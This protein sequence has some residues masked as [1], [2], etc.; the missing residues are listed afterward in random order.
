VQACVGTAP[1]GWLGPLAY[2]EG[3]VGAADAP[4]GC[5][6]G[7]G[8]PIDLHRDLAPPTAACDCTC[9]AQGQ[10]CDQNTSLHLYDDAACG[11]ECATASPQACN[12]VSGC[13]G[14]QGSLSATA[15]MPSGGSCVPIIAASPPPT[16]LSDARLCQP[17]D[18]SGCEDPSQACAPA[19]AQPYLSQRCVMR[20][21]ADGGALPAC[22]ADYPNAMDP[23][24]QTFTDGRG[25]GVCAC[26]GVS[27][28]TCSGKLLLSAGADCSTGL[29]YTLNSGCKT[30]DLGPGNAQPTH[31]GGQY[32]LTPGACSVTAPPDVV[33]IAEPTGPVTVVCCQ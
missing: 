21:I 11:L 32:V 20:V 3:T 13:L 6:K 12:A 18:A 2:W 33:G 23:L 14:S 16:W 15:P 27:G 29:E 10:T 31:V 5:P 19:P 22:P 7:Y 26:S 9:V 24:Y 28:G 17:S 30:Y 1:A 4:P 8:E 25:C